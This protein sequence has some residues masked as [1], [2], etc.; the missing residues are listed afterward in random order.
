MPLD[1]DR[2]ARITHR[3]ALTATPVLQGAG[4]CKLARLPPVPGVLVGRIDNGPMWSRTKF[5]N[6]DQVMV[7]MAKDEAKLFKMK[8]GGLLPGR[9][10][11][12]LDAMELVT[13][14]DLWGD[15]Y[16]PLTRS[17]AILTR[18]TELVMAQESSADVERA[19]KDPTSQM[20]L[21]R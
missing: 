11:A 7:S 17:Q 19:F 15:E 12:T 14:F 20:P 4:R 16:T 2:A 10:L 8:L 18:V 6:G 5:P 21:K 9:T 1:L 3:R 13:V